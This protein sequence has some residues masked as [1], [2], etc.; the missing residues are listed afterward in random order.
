MSVAIYALTAVIALI[1]IVGKLIDTKLRNGRDDK[2]IAIL[3][4]IKSFDQRQTTSI[5]SLVKL[6]PHIKNGVDALVEMSKSEDP[7]TGSP[8]I[9]CKYQGEE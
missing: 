3:T 1:A 2:I 7:R 6:Q 4:E 8:R 9:F 5:E